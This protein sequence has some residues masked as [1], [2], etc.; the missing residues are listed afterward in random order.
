MIGF[1]GYLQK[2]GQTSRAFRRQTLQLILVQ[3]QRGRQK[4][5]FYCFTLIGN[6][7]SARSKNKKLWKANNFSSTK[8]TEKA[9][10]RKRRKLTINA[11]RHERQ[12]NEMRHKSAKNGEKM[13]KII[14]EKTPK[15]RHKRQKSTKN[16]EKWR[17]NA[18]NDEKTL[19]GRTTEI[20]GQYSQHFF[21]FQQLT[22]APNK[23]GCLSLKIF[24]ALCILTLQLIGPICKLENDV[25]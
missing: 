16:I 22:N 12:K 23:L 19:K 18:E 11:E 1:W 8:K 20:Q 3:S 25:L 24:L 17:E 7:E 14:N 2:L 9:T 13:P 21:F 6:G 10:T 4:K 5:V 15:I